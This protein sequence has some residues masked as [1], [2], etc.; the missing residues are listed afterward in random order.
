MSVF[1]GYPSQS[2]SDWIERKHCFWFE[3]EEDGL[4]IQLAPYYGSA[5]PANIHISISRDDKKTWTAYD[6]YV[7]KDINAGERV[8]FRAGHPDD[9]ESF[10]NERI[11]KWNEKDEQV[12]DPITFV[13]N[14]KKVGAHGNLNCLLQKYGQKYTLANYCYYGMFQDCTSLTQAPELPAQTLADNC[15]NGMFFSCTSLTTAPELPATTLASSCYYY[16]FYGCTSLTTAP[17]LPATTLASSCYY[18]MFQDCTSLTQA[19]ELP[20]QTLADNCYNGMFFSCTSLTTA[21]EL[22]ATT[23]ANSCYNGMFNYCSSLTS[24]PELPATTLA[25][26]CYYFMFSEC[27]KLSSIEVNHTAWNPTNATTNWV[28]GVSSTGTFKCPESLDTSTRDAS[29]V[30]SGWTIVTK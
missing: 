10:E 21:P 5:F 28:Y 19:P 3:A 27:S 22:P 15:Y 12:E 26:Y 8:Y 25:D 16:M 20:A 18:S 9:P 7:I 13:F 6:G 4:T 17:E 11:C 2:V 24:A 29:Y 30:P 1:L 14:D 23:L